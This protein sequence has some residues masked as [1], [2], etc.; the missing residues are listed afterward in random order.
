[1]KHIILSRMR[2]SDKELLD[3]YLIVT[4]DILIPC[5]KSQTNKNFIWG[6]IIFEEHEEYVKNYLGLDFMSFLN[7]D[8]VA[9][10]VKDNDINIQTRH[11]MDDYMSSNYIEKIQNVYEDNIKKWN[12]F[13]IQSQPVRLD[14]HTKEEF[15]MGEYTN[16]RNSMFLSL[17]QSNVK[18]HIFER[19]HGQMYEITDNI[20]SLPEGYTKWV[21][22]GN[23]KSCKL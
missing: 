11:D 17:C 19:Q 1:M 2:F 5:L 3:K 7:I 22:H 23:N 21:I 9:S 4:K 6:L 15:K 20:I 12:I 8:E 16:V 18:H 10:Y 14:Y 13:L